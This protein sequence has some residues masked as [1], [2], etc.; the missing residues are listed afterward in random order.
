MRWRPS[1]LV[2]TERSGTA[3]HSSESHASRSFC[4]ASDFVIVSELTVAS[5]SSRNDAP[6]SCIVS[7]N[8]PAGLY[9]STGLSAATR[10]RS[11]TPAGTLAT[12]GSAPWNAST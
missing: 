2:A 4:T 1:G 5:K 12:V 6:L 3:A 9:G 11:S 8:A 7:S 10:R